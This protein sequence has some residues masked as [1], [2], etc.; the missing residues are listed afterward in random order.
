SELLKL[1]LEDQELYE[2][3]FEQDGP[4]HLVLKS[5][6]TMFLP[7]GKGGRHITAINKEGITEKSWDHF[8][9][10]ALQKAS[11]GFIESISPGSIF[12]LLELIVLIDYKPA[13]LLLNENA[14]WRE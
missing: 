14:E 4:T 9:R 3:M 8:F 13:R 11:P 7:D 1:V 2:K 5:L 12:E 10:L 6:L